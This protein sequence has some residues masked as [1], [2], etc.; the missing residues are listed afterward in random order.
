MIDLN[1]WVASDH[2][3]GHANVN[4]FVPKRLEYSSNPEE[5]MIEK[6]NELVGKF[7]N[8]LFMGDFSFK[9]PLDY[10]TFIS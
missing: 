2:H 7:D 1:T 3:F 10:S 8:V 4:S 6:H 9:N 5:F